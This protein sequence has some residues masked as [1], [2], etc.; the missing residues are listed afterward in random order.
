MPGSLQLKA[1]VAAMGIAAMSTAGAATS[2]HLHAHSV[3]AASTAQL[4]S[5]L[6]L[7]SGMGFAARQSAPNADGTRT[8][9]MQQTFRGVPV[10]GRSIAVHQDTSGRALRATGNLL[11]SD[12]SLALMSVTPKLS[13][14]DAVQTLKSHNGAALVNAAT[15]HPQSEL[16][17]YPSE[18]G[19]PRL[20]YLT[21]YVIGGSQP[22]RPTALID[23]NTGQIIK[24]WDGLTT[25]II[26]ATGPG[27]NQKT[28]Q[29]TWGQNG[30]P[31]LVAT[32][33]GSTCS[34]SN[35][36]VKT[37]NMNHATSGS[38][39]LWTFTCANSSGDATNG[40]YGPVNDAHHFGQVVHDMYNSWF[41]APPLNQVL[42]MRVHYGSS[43]ENAF[44]DGTAMNFG[45]GASTFYPLVSLD[46]TSH[47]ISH[48][49]TEQ[50]SNLQYSG[51]SG[52][53][54]EA[55]SD[56]A[57][58]AA[59]YYDRGSND[60]LVG[61]E[62]IKNGTALRYM[63]NPTQD[64]G[65][66]DN[67]A[68]YTSGLDVHY[69]SG[70]YNKAYCTLAKKSGWTT[71]KAFEVFERANALYWTSTATF[72]SG[73]CGVEDA[74]DDLGYASSD[75]SAAFSV[76]GVTCPSSGG[77]GG[78]GGGSSQLE[79]GVPATGL[80]GSSGTQLYYTVQVPAGASNLVIAES[81]G[82]GDA[83][84]YVKFGS[85]PTT[86][87][88]DCRPYKSGNNESCSFASPQAGTYYVMLRGYSSFSG[89][90]LQASWSTSGGGGGG[91]NGVFTNT[92]N[93]SIP[94]GGSATSSIAVSG[95]SGNAPSDLQVHVKI[96]HSYRGDLR[97]TLIAPSGATATLKSPSG[98]DGAANVDTTYSVDA[99]SVAA[100]GTW[101]LKVDD[102]YTGDTGYLDEWSLTF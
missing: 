62:I 98:S 11:Q 71:K 66:I 25:G 38:G 73:A 64:G 6:G 61:A 28:G 3:N 81:G 45:D 79:N 52:G 48:G 34:L 101:K 13:G 29:Y 42:L 10:Y 96:V 90:S 7:G 44:W 85:Q 100:N 16:F 99:S 31:A 8:V 37:Y 27:G 47:E 30:L 4:S 36:D 92:S 95:Q 93:L 78:G 58:E 51:Q 40:A 24:Q 56:M 76:V 68:D 72:N 5:Q 35:N 46:V 43:Y 21:S 69:S 53:M 67:A 1:L 54:N 50:H 82:S 15:R 84:L 55:F 20:V 88:Y 26:D 23:A 57:G 83:D 80:S 22:A 70:V 33:S 94:D 59:E 17:V 74:A 9:R 63:C 89:V 91:G 86:S 39:T 75:V 77:G 65:S 18:A 32:Q 49:F 97:I 2:Q 19:A 41:G 14:D 87:S 60:W 102:V 12:S